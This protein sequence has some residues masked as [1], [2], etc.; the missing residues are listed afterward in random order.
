MHSHPPL[1]LKLQR[2]TPSMQ[3][4][5]TR[6]PQTET[7]HTP[8]H[9]SYAKHRAMTLPTVL[10]C[11]TSIFSSN[12]TSTSCRCS[13][14]MTELEVHPMPHQ[15]HLRVSKSYNFKLLTPMTE[16]TSSHQ[17]R[18]QLLQ[19][20]S[21]LETNQPEQHLLLQHRIFTRAIFKIGKMLPTNRSYTK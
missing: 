6:L 7:W 14:N 16:S 11:R 20:P 5:S 13:R 10:S 18:A 21:W 8:N 12:T 1:I 2:P 9:A 19:Q 4:V 3:S 15:L 17:C